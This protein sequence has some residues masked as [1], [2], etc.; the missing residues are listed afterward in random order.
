MSS[1]QKCKQFTLVT[2]K[3]RLT[4]FLETLSI[5]IPRERKWKSCSLESQKECINLDR[6]EF[7][8]KL[9]RVINWLSEWE[10]VI[11]LFKISLN[12]T[13]HKKREEF[14]EKTWFQDFKTSFLCKIL[15]QKP[16]ILMKLARLDLLK[17]KI[18]FLLDQLPL[19][20]Q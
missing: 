20:L 18:N 9:E 19:N 3:T 4:L 14:K 16:T 11:C 17:E 5:H 12:N 2:E 1:L 15:Q 8:L 7:T 10:E 13:L 6:N